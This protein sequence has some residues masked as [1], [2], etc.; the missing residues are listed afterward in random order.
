MHGVDIVGDVAA[1]V[2][3]LSA[4]RITERYMTNILLVHG[5]ELGQPLIISPPLL[6]AVT[7]LCFFRII[8]YQKK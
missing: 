3:G 1:K 5:I 6:E 7:F 8:L 2:R 4:K